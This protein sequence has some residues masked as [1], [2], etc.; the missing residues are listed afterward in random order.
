MRMR[1]RQR[2]DHGFSRS[3]HHTPITGFRI[4]P[5]VDIDGSGQNPA[6]PGHL[7]AALFGRFYRSLS[8]G[9]GGG[10]VVGLFG[11]SAL[12][13]KRA[14][15]RFEIYLIRSQLFFYFDRLVFWQNGRSFVRCEFLAENLLKIRLFLPRIVG[16]ARL[17]S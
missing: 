3:I 1:N 2:V 16:A 15:L 8:F 11:L 12:S 5:P 7:P 14:E 4:N 10:A 6:A 13:L 17:V 9:E